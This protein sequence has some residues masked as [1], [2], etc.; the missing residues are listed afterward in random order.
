MSDWAAWHRDLLAGKPG[1]VATLTRGGLALAALP[2]A[3]SM[4][5]RNR[6]YD[7]GWFK[8]HAAKVPVVSVGN[9]TLGGTGKTPAV[10]YLARFYRDRDVQVGILSRGYGTQAGRNDEALVLEENLPDVPHLQGRD[11]VA[12]AQT[13]A[14]EL[15]SELLLLDDG[16]QHRRLR[17]DLDVV[18]LD[19]TNPWGHG[20]VFP[21]GTLREPGSGLKRAGAVL[22]TRCDQVPSATVASLR[23]EVEN[24]LPGKPL[25]ETRHAPTQLINADGSELSLEMLHGQPVA[26]LCALGNPAA[27]VATLRSQGANLVAERFF[28]DH[29]AYTKAD[30]DDLAKWAATLPPA[31]WIVTSQKDLVKLRISRLGRMPVWAVRI[32]IEPLSDPAAL[33]ELLNSLIPS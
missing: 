27:F 10:E 23:Q 31:C 9:L 14:E 12:L 32:A 1:L 15:E 26:A 17:R 2:Y 19:A 3:G 24:R 7:L 5:L 16:F 25:V 4:M 33:H 11:R 29:H 8:S 20:R 28:P 6:L 13:A 21:R 30:V 18:L 22:L